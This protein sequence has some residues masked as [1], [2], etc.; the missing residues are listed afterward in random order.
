MNAAVTAGLEAIN[1]F[2]EFLTSEQVIEPGEKLDQVLQNTTAYA[3]PKVLG[4]LIPDSQEQ[5]DQIVIRANAHKIKLYTFSRG[6][7]W[8]LGSRLPYEDECMLV[9]LS[10]LNRIISVDEHFH[11]ALIEPGVTQA[12]LSSY[13]EERRLPLMLNVTG[14]SP[15]TSVLA[16]CLER[17]SGFLAHRFL[18]LKGIEVL[19]ADGS[20]VRSG[21]WNQQKDSHEVVHHFDFGIGPDWRG[22]FSQSNL[23][24]VTQM[25]VN[26]IPKKECQKMIWIKVEQNHLPA[27]VEVLRDLYQRN[28]LHSVTHIGNDKRMKIENRNQG[29]KT[30][31]TAMAMVQGSASFV[32]FLESEI[33]LYLKRLDAQ[34]EFVDYQKAQQQDLGEIFGCHIG[35]PTDYF[36]RAMYQSEGA[37]LK[38]KNF[39]IDF[40]PYGMLCC[41]PILPARAK[42]IAEA[43][44]VLDSID[45]DFG[46]I[47]AATLNPMNDQHL[48]SVINIYFNRNDAGDT[49][50][51]HKANEAMTQRFLDKGFKFYRFDV[52][53][54]SKFS[55][56]ENPHWRLVR[57][58]KEALDPNRILSPGRY[59]R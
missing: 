17:G 46:I 37:E 9:E 45:R 18:D 2:T 59:E 38:E 32:H 12:Q 1:L 8:G 50:R 14:S 44:E 55:D 52:K 7:N 43:V 47:P 30:V 13:L 36:L 35:K 33:P 10:R 16:N 51:A 31:W 23:G 27:L 42:E 4:L 20:R 40:G 48:E 6:L 5:L 41:L 49:E 53:L 34:F 28:Y 54:F 24:I 57:R 19:L 3:A 58:L 25:A 22:L 56:P 11:F 29:K 39:Q 15:Q 26:L 21:F